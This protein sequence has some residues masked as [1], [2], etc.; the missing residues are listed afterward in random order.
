V[1]LRTPTLAEFLLLRAERFSAFALAFD[2]PGRPLPDEAAEGAWWQAEVL[3]GRHRVALADGD[4]GLP[5]A[6]LHAFAFADRGRSCE[7]GF[8]VFPA[9]KAGR[10]L[11]RAALRLW[12]DALAA[13]LPAL[14][15]VTAETNALN[16]PALGV[17]AAC[18]F[19]A[20]DEYQ[21]GPI[22]WKVFSLDLVR[23]PVPA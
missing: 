20:D 11:G 23:R 8:S 19:A 1:K 17:L 6:V 12:L 7:V 10:G 3:T 2:D 9:E 22:L 16:G 15:T 21:D 14:E 18:G 4:D 5:C 13:D